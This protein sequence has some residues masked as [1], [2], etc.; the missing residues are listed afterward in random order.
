MNEPEG[1]DKIFFTGKASTEELRATSL[2]LLLSD[3]MHIDDTGMGRELHKAGEAAFNTG[4][5]PAYRGLRILGALCTFHMNSDDPADTWHPRWTDGKARTLT[6]ADVR[7]EQNSA[8]AVILP[9]IAHPAL[10]ARVADV[11]WSNDRKQYKAA[12]EAVMAYC[13]CVESRLKGRFKD[14]YEG[15]IE[16]LF[17]P[18]NLLQRALFINASIGK[19]K[20]LPE[21]LQ[22]AFSLLYQRAIEECHYVVFARLGELATGYKI[23]TWQKV[24]QDSEYLVSTS[25]ANDYPE[26]RKK[27]WALA[28]RCYEFLKDR[29]GRQRCLGSLVDET[30]KMCE[31]VSSYAAKASWMRQAI[32]ELRIAGGFQE[33]IKNIIEDMRLAQLASLDEIS[34]FSIPFDLSEERELITDKFSKLLLPDALFHFAVVAESPSVELLKQVAYEN[35]STGLIA[36]LFPKKIY[37]DREGK[38]IAETSG[39]IKPE[40]PD[41][42]WFRENCLSVM[43]IFHHNIVEGIIKPARHAVMHNYP[44]ESRHFD[45]ITSLS[46]FVPFGYE[47]IFSLGF[48]R[49]WQGDCASAAFLL[50][51]QLENSLRLIL[52]NAGRDTFKTDRGEVQEDRSLSGLLDNKRKELEDILGSDLVNEI[53][54]LFHFKPGPSL[55]HKIAHGKLTAGD[56][57]STACIYACW[58]IYR[59]TCI[60]LLPQ[61]QDQVASQIKLS[62]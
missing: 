11:V 47:H 24:A 30:L 6:P 27:V 16:S 22:H 51:P 13:E 59:L 21:F 19:K 33:R 4:N 54:L 61:W 17:E 57:Y 37:L 9:E 60:P 7:G 15:D 40:G 38:V 53:D 41:D 42:E 58:F 34:E 8:L 48:A 36:H 46:P 2:D 14:K 52:M 44:V 12:N 50:I 23:M 55:R 39:Q 45:A 62:L 29:E 35:R 25:N 5:M 3:Y 18:T 20:A 43:D 28:A 49:F 31:Q 56:C 26:A 32:N 10:R 1:E